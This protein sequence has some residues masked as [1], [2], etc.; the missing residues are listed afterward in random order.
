M[1]G[2]HA[3]SLLQ[4]Q[5]AS[6]TPRDQTHYQQE[7]TPLRIKPKE[8]ISG[9]LRCFNISKSQSEQVRNGYEKDEVVDFFLS[10]LS[11]T[12]NSTLMVQ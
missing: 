11:D 6:L 1:F 5:C 4:A 10:S 2:D 8:S 9:F 7:F 12:T 3:L